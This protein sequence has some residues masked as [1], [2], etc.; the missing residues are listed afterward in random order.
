MGPPPQLVGAIVTIVRGL[1]PDRYLGLEPTLDAFRAALGCTM[2]LVGLR[3]AAAA[4][5]RGPPTPVGFNHC[6]LHSAGARTRNRRQ[7]STGRDPL[8]AAA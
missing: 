1:D 3:A 8:P 5:L 7:Q 6:A 4:H 2:V